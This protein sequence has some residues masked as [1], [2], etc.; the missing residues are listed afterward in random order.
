MLLVLCG[1]VSTVIGVMISG[2]LQDPKP[3]RARLGAKS[4]AQQLRE[5][6]E[7][8]FHSNT[9]NK[10]PEAA[11]GGGR[12][13]AS[14]D[15]PA[16]RSE[17]SATAVLLSEGE[18]GRDPWG[19]PYHYSV[20][21]QPNSERRIILVWSDGPDGKPDTDP[22]QIADGSGAAHFKGDDVGYALQT[23]P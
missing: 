20:R 22:Q 13:L 15:G 9:E 5:R 23:R 19:R 8:A 18:L 10:S 12:A 3:E 6:H 2:F 16:K 14:I 1:F 21:P 4:I 17:E 11:L 7:T